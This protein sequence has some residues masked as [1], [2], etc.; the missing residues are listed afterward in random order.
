[1]GA[2]H[3]AVS[4]VSVSERAGRWC[5][6]L[7]AQGPLVPLKFAGRHDSP[8]YWTGEVNISSDS[9]TETPGDIL[10]PN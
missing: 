7:C 2:R 9:Q 5:L 8:D 3:V 1:M 4:T 10:R 6:I